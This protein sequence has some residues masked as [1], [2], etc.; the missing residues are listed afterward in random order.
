M[1][2]H[3][4]RRARRADLREW[5]R[6][7]NQWNFCSCLARSF[8]SKRS[9]TSLE[10][11]IRSKVE[12]VCEH[13][14]HLR[15]S[16]EAIDLRQLFPCVTA[17][18]VTEYVFPQ[19]FDFLSTSD[20]A[21]GWRQLI[22]QNLR[23]SNFLKHYPMMWSVI[24]SI[25][26]SFLLAMSPSLKDT[27]KWERTNQKVSERIVDNYDPKQELHEKRTIFH[28]L[29]SSDLPPQENTYER[30]WQEASSIVGAG[31]ETT[32][33]TL[34]VIMYYLISDPK[35]MERLKVSNSRKWALPPHFP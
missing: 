19:S 20:L 30:L 9:V 7:N 28:E 26:D 34:T 24:R 14:N 13:L 25:P 11:L 32:A 2:I 3:A 23:A 5:S 29:L 12:K 4:K 31:T 8:F 1:P 35:I 6:H 22:D 15:D 10:P 16:S 17:D 21:P 27:I 18:I 33:N